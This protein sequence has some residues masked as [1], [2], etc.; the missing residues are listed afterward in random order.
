M[1]DRP[2]PELY[3]V[4]TKYLNQQ[5]KRNIKRFP[6]EFMFT[7][8]KEERNELVAICNRLDSWKHST[9]LPHAFTQEQIARI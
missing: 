4:K 7:L 5:V 2:L 6:L 1:I 8:T 9:V 3:G